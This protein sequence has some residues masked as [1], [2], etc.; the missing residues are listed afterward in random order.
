MTQQ[1]MRLSGVALKL[2]CHGPR[3]AWEFL[4]GL[5]LFHSSLT[6]FSLI[7]ARPEYGMKLL[8]PYDVRLH[9]IL[10]HDVM[11]CFKLWADFSVHV[12]IHTWTRGILVRDPSSPLSW[13]VEI[14][15]STGSHLQL[16]SREG[17]R[18]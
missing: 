8:G 18:I 17:V 4:I 10:L 7:G 2:L 3:N 9:R 15:N 5:G 1:N 12:L 6:F 14:L 11:K 16:S 13:V